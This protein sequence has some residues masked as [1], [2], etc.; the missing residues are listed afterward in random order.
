MA[1]PTSFLSFERLNLHN[2]H[3]FRRIV[4]LWGQ[5]LELSL[6]FALDSQ[7]LADFQNADALGVFC[8][9]YASA[10]TIALA[11]VVICTFG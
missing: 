9:V 10:D 6:N 4:E 11:L 1:I 3:I 7:F 8:T 5:V 2:I